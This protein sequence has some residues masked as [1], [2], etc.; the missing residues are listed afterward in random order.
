ML[1]SE[2]ADVP[3]G[4]KVVAVGSFDGVHLGHQYL[5]RQALS[6]AKTLKAP[7]LVYT[8][9]PPTK[10]FTRGEGFLMDLQEKVEALREVGVELI[11]AVPFNE[12][13]A[14]RP[15]EAFLEDLRALQ[16]SR[17]YVG[18]DFRFGQGRA[19]GPE[20]LERVA[21]TRVVPLLSLGGEAVKSSRIR[22]LLREGR[23]EEARHL[24][25]RLYGAYGV[26]VE[27]DRMGRRLGFPTA[28]LA[29]HPLKVLPPGV[30]AVEAEGAFGRYK[31]VANVGT[32]PT[33]GGEERRLEVHLLGFAGELYGE[34]VRVRFLKRLREERRFP[35]LEALRAQIAEDVAE[36]RAYF[37][38]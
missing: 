31:G 7:L 38:L 37:G 33:L 24:L 35:S 22:A 32:R 4:P 13:F 1:F 12:E 21:P 25:G 6:E 14:R 16:A 29:V 8:F 36:A 23:V 34:E 18:E 5:L 11:L 9:D 27:G 10:V 20:A 19:G 2:V 30:F 17:I 28:N 3:K 15:P 26:V